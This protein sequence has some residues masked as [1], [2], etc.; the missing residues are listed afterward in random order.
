MPTDSESPRIAAT[1]IQSS[2]PSLT[3]CYAP[4]FLCCL[5]E[6][7]EICSRGV[8]EYPQVKLLHHGQDV[9][10]DI[11][12]DSLVICPDLILAEDVDLDG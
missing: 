1:M 12:L 4:M 7:A 10:E 2:V 3:I 11:R 5:P 6:R 9:V 8:L